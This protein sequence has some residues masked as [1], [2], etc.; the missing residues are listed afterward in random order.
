MMCQACRALIEPSVKVC[1]LCGRES[2]PPLRARASGVVGSGYFFSFLILTIN[3]ALFILMGVAEINR[4]GE[5]GAFISQPSDY[6][7]LDFGGR[8]I[9]SL[10]NGQ[11]WLLV[12]PIF[13]HI[14]IMH[15]MFN[16]FA[17]YQIGPLAEEA[18]GSQKFIFV[19]LATGVAGNIGSFIFSINGAGASGAI[20]GL[21][22]LMAIYGYRQGGSMGRSL[23]RQMLIWAG[24]GLVFGLVI[25]ADN[26]NHLGGLFTGAAL[27]FLL[28]LEEP[29]TQRNQVL[30]NAAAVSCAVLIVASFV[31]VALNYG[32]FQLEPVTAQTSSG[33]ERFLEMTEGVDRVQAALV[34]SFNWESAESRDPREIASLLRS[35]AAALDRAGSL[36]ADSDAIRKRLS[37]LALKRAKAFDS[38]ETDPAAVIA[39]RQSDREEMQRAREDFQIWYKRLLRS[40]ERQQG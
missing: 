11:M 24:I 40:Q 34:E 4:G 26:V 15:L 20:F 13:L 22:G 3:M 7:F 30:W 28:K 17:L 16:S 5:I 35:A 25:G 1:P 32:K 2:V 38:A 29:G 21:I 9:E 8:Y 14:G 10:L 6:V 19:Y 37:D 18:L 27:G 36:D 31:M 23:M 33:F 12:T 39:S